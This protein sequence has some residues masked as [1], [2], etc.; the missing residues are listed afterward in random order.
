VDSLG[1]SE[2]PAL[3]PLYLNLSGRP[4]LVVGAGRVAAR[5]VGPLLA[6]GA[7]VTVV[8]PDV[9][10]EFDTLSGR[11]ALS[12]LKRPFTA[13]DLD[14]K[15]LVI[16]ATGSAQVNRRVSELAEGACVLC[17]VVDEPDLCTFQ[18]PAVVRRGLLQLA[19]STGGSSPALAAHLR[20]RLEAEFGPAWAELIDAL[21]DLRRHYRD[22]YP[23]DIATRGRLLKEFVESEAPALLT[24][25]GD[26]A[27]FNRELE[28]WKAR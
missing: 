28:R 27:A 7:R 9:S 24:E 16:A 11:D 17:N 14:G 15:W 5:K 18:V 3:Y 23:D 8:A 12:I 22:K 2:R 26:R 25:A 19:V 4:V 6:A 13:G 1:P 10:E 20:R 21:G